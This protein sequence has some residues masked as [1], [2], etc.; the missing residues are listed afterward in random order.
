M[1]PTKIAIVTGGASGLG[2]A[3]TQK[4]IEAGIK[5]III[6]RDEN[7]LQAAATKF[8]S[9]CIYKVC[10]LSKIEEIP[11]LVNTIV[12][13]YG[14]PNILV[15]NAGINMKKPFAEVT[16]QD[17]QSI[18]QTNLTSVFV[19]S[20][21][22]VKK[23]MPTGSGCIVNISSMAS[24][25]GIP[26]VI[27]Y[28][29]TKSAIEGMTRAMATELSPQGIRVNC[30]APGF[31]ATDMSAKALD[32]DPTR[33]QKVLSRTPMG[34]LGLPEDIADAVLFLASDAA[35]YITGVVLPVDGG[36]SIGF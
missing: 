4:F 27:A 11:S 7:K 9:L 31:I 21:E 35:K 6:G 32:N 19:L 33:K 5:T 22:V 2:L 26:Y 25:Y 29:A 14:V 3:T 23:M 10:D 8:G 16:D 12:Q 24:Q 13:E 36:N 28:T 18:V 1:N 15:N 34:K 17:F 30:V 20:R